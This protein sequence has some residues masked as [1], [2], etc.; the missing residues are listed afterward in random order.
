MSMRVHVSMNVNKCVCISVNACESVW[1]VW[2][3]EHE[4]AR[5]PGV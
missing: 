5:A 4:R 2:E 1:R 3:R